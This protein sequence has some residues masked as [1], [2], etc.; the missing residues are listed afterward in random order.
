MG[1]RGEEEGGSSPHTLLSVLLAQA[2]DQLCRGGGD[3]GSCVLQ[4]PMSCPVGQ[5]SQPWG[6][7]PRGSRRCF[8]PCN[9][10]SGR[11]YRRTTP[12]AKYK[13]PKMNQAPIPLNI[14]LEPHLSPVPAARGCP[15]GPAGGNQAHGTPVPCRV[16]SQGGLMGR[17]IPCDQG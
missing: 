16:G 7:E 1:G 3:S 9:T 8:C 11:S 6:R 5:A 4:Q 12:C 13:G 2:P 17:L 14:G 10:V 15:R